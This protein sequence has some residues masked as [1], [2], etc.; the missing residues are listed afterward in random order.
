VTDLREDSLEFLCCP[1]CH[2]DLTL[3]TEKTVGDEVIF[4]FLR[5]KVCNRQYV[6]KSGIPDFL[7]PEFLNEKDKR[8]MHEYDRM[9][10][11]Y[12][13]LM[14]LLIPLFSVGLMLLE[15]YTWTKRLQ[16][17]KGAHVLDISTGT[18]QNLPWLIRQIGS[19]GRLTAM[20]ISEGMLTYAK[21]KIE[22]KKW[23]NIELQRANASHLPYKDDVFDAVIHVGGIN[24]FGEKERALHEMVRVAQPN[25]KIVIVDEGLVPEKQNS[26]IGKFL[27][28]TN[29][30]YACRPP[31]K[32]LPKGIRN[33]QL[34][35]KNDPLWPHYIMDFQ[36]S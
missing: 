18:G 4:G 32:L 5:C 31:T 2:G 8:W 9:F 10:H 17:K 24:T 15:R 12:D 28:K 27:L 11:S 22:R 36:K 23:R 1:A 21:L 6:I 26:F 20:D 33:L 7:L 16:T 25:S 19:S 35:W 30:L 3:N 34:R 13:I 29:A 14:C